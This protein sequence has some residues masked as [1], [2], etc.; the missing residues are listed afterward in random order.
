MMWR[1]P[2]R[3]EQNY[4]VIVCGGGAAGVGAAV[5]AARAG[6]RVCLVEKYGFLGGA[7]TTAQVLAYCGFY[8]QGA[9]PVAAVGGVG[10]ELLAS[11][12]KYGLDTTPFCSET[13]GNWI[14]RIEPELL[15]LTMDDL[16]VRHGVDVQLHTRVAAATRTG[17]RIEAV[18]LAGMEG[19]WHAVADAFVDASGDANLA[20]LAGVPYRI[21]NREGLLQA[22]TLPMRIG[23]V[24]PEVSI[25][26]PALCASVARYNEGGEFPISRSDGGI[27]F[28]LPV[29]SDIWWMAVDLPMAEVSS[30]CFTAME[31]KGRAMANDYL[32]MLRKHMPGFASA[33]LVATGPQIGV[34]ETR[35][36]A[37]RYE[38]T[39]EDAAQG[40][41]SDDAVARAAWPIELHTQP[42]R[43]T[44]TPLGGAGYFHV[45]YDA[46]SAAGIENL[47]YG[48]RVIGADPEAYASVR[49]MGTAFATGEAAGVSAVD[50]IESNHLRNARTVANR[51]R[52]NGA[53]V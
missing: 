9:K 31:M 22:T 50:Y 26:R 4:D 30:R 47:W 36:P 3:H 28:R 33:Y 17:E 10:A 35:H 21:G 32:H 37:A 13:T 43:P 16:L 8:Q 20:M 34:R 7:A 24:P 27:M 5:G 51:L 29:S 38:M 25:D 44:Y 53:I 45:P 2:H 41:T 52:A 14:V 18:T 23:G 19:R 15:K 46:I 42:G 40:K 48:G 6:A 11:L 39:L 12:S 1:S 49:V